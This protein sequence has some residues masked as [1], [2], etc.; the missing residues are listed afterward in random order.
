[1]GN[2]LPHLFCWYTCSVKIPDFLWSKIISLVEDYPIWR[3]NYI[4]E[5]RECEWCLM[6]RTAYW[7]ALHVHILARISYLK[8][9]TDENDPGLCARDMR[10]LQTQH[11]FFF[12]SLFSLFLDRLSWFHSCSVCRYRLSLAFGSIGLNR[13]VKMTFRSNWETKP[14][15][16]RSTEG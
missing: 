11:V 4:E 9:A 8:S 14:T 15:L 12:I 6:C 7:C 13:C 5:S 2:S 3:R 16:S 1:M 10:Y